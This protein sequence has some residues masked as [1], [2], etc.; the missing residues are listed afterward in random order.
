VSHR[1]PAA[2]SGFTLIEVVLALAITGMLLA[3]V[4]AVAQSATSMAD[5]VAT[6]QERA[7]VGHSFTGLLRRTFEQVP[8]NAKV[9][10]KLT[11]G[12]SS[13]AVQSDVV[14]RDYPL[15][16]AW[17]GVEAGAKTVIFRTQ[18]DARGTLAAR[19]LYLTEEQ[20]EAYDDNRLRDDESV[21]G[22]T[23]V[24][25]VRF[26]QW[27]FWDD[28]TEEW[29]EEWDPQKYANRRP[30]LVNLYLKFSSADSVGENITFWIP[31]M[32]NPS[33]FASGTAGR[34]GRP[35]GG[36]G[37]PGGEGPGGPGG[38][39][40][41]PGGGGPGGGP[42]FDRGGGRGGRGGP[43]GGGGGRGGMGGGGGGGGGRGGPGGG[44]PP[45]GGGR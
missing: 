14:F 18:P 2:S 6:S 37:G 38:P 25:G 42:G 9:E 40:A 45:G 20:A 24:D 12:G 17:A 22:L 16:F 30:T 15:A 10:L 23:L 41:G 34:G 5:E 35:G 4:F 11:S 21:V 8:G 19:V 32:A 3:G 39:G 28:R 29:V 33:S 31:T 7:M 43:P 27:Y 26:C 36:E 13:G 44:R 1:R